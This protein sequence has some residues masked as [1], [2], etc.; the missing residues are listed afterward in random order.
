MAYG[1]RVSSREFN[2][3]S[4]N[5]WICDIWSDG[6]YMYVLD[7]DDKR[8]YVYTMAGAR[9]SSRE[10]TLSSSNEKPWG[11][12]NDGTYFY[13]TDRD[14]RRIYVY[15]MTGTR[16]SSREFTLSSAVANANDLWGDSSYLY[17]L[18]NSDNRVYV[19]THGGTRQS[20]R[21]FN[22]PSSAVPT[23][24]WGDGTYFY[25]LD[26]DTESV[27]VYTTSGS[28][29]SSL[30]IDLHSANTNST[31]M[32][33]DGNYLYVGDVTD[34]RIYVYELNPMATN[35]PATGRPVIAGTAQV[36]QTLT[37]TAGNIADADGLTNVSYK[38]QWWRGAI[39]IT[40]ATSSSYTLVSADEGELM[41]VGYS[42]RDDADNAESRP[43]LRTSA[44]SAAPVTPTNSPATGRPVISGTAQVGETLASTAGSIADADGLTNVSYSYLWRE[45]GTVIQGATR[46]SYT[47]SAVDLGDTISVT[48][49]FRDDAGNSES[50]TSLR[51]EAVSAKAATTPVNSPAT[52]RPSLTGTPNIGQTLTSTAGDIADAD[53]L[54]NVNYIP[55]WYADGRIIHG[56]HDF[57]FTLT[58]EHEGKY[59]TVQY[60]FLDDASNGEG[61]Y[62]RS[63]GPVAVM[64]TVI[65]SATGRPTISGTPQVGQTLTAGIGTIA[66]ENGLPTTT[67]PTGYTL[68]WFTDD[69]EV[70]SNSGTTFMCREADIGNR[71]WIR[72]QFTD[73][74]G[75]SETTYSL[76]TN[77]VTAIPA[78]NSAAT[79]RP[80]IT[81]TAQVGET[82]TA[83]VGSIGDTNG[84]TGASYTVRWLR[85][86]AA[87]TGATFR[88]YTLVAADL[89]TNISTRWSFTD[90]DGFSEARSSL[91]TSAVVAA[92]VIDPGPNIRFKQSGAWVALEKDK[93]YV[94]VSGMWETVQ[95]VHVK[96][97]GAWISI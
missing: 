11:I 15:S 70:E 13:V 74:G 87:I 28:R 55:V 88:T 81:G 53:G 41:A 64:A 31:G 61:R 73:Q 72:V 21:E 33:G 12:W 89:G 95:D 36:G 86:D 54:T 66:D 42:F 62:S 7:F 35:S 34:D 39:A 63:L 24:L 40:T 2:L 96:V 1:D 45:G 3:Y 56:A 6:T 65:H 77:Q 76:R 59:I 20:S 84:L 46:S 43:S 91:Q 18:D 58:D 52:G 17:I 5:G 48:Y 16:Q 90:D 14:D 57:S 69:G 60:T 25:I 68:T 49:N 51:T 44:V 26:S 75:F 82:L 32:W 30:D 83:S 9:Q 79:G 38:Y 29:Q 47:L 8:V 85:G 27:L 67:F 19:Y 94:K 92:P 93:A 80:V 10:F 4:S 23:G 22:L 71:V 37:S 50:R 78:V 97:N